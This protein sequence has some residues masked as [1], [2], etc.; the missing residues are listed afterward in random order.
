ML[1]LVLACALFVA[2]IAVII[3]M[4]TDRSNAT[5]VTRR[6][7]VS[8][9]NS[10]PSS[11]SLDPEVVI[12]KE[13]LVVPA[14]VI[15]GKTLLRF[16]CEKTAL[17]ASETIQV[18]VKTDL[19]TWRE[20]FVRIYYD[21]EKLEITH[22]PVNGLVRKSISSWSFDVKYL[23][24]LNSGYIVRLLVKAKDSNID[25]IFKYLTS[26]KDSNLLTT[27]QGTQALNFLEILFAN[28]DG[29]FSS[30]SHVP[31]AWPTEYLIPN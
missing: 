14:I 3:V 24:T 11:P 17:N 26:E 10:N 15:A 28:K 25:N 31:L 1:L 4:E 5:S 9:R 2:V 16:E 6:S 29:T 8:N 18:D 22:E 27:N 12:P 20:A 23:A 30:P 7:A 13:P 21:P 19:L